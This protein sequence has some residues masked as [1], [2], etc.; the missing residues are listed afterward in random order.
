M[1]PA[2]AAAMEDAF[3][4]GLGA[5]TLMIGVLCLAGAVFAAIALPGN[6][7]VPPAEREATD[8]SLAEVSEH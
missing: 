8:A 1:G 7:F 3:M 4:V 2:V 6:R 5:A